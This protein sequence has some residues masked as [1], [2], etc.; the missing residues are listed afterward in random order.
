MERFSLWLNRNSMYVALLAALIATCGSLYFSEVR[1]YVPCVLCWYQRILM[2]PLTGVIAV[3]LLRRDRNLPYYVLP[4]S[5]YGVGMSGYHYLLEKTDLFAG[6]A[7]CAQGVSCTT[8]WINWFGFVTIPF[9]AFTAFLIIT[10]MSVI[11]LLNGEP[12]AEDEEGERLRTPWL[13][14]SGVVVAVLA[15]FAALFISGSASQ[16]AASAAPSP[17]AAM[18][19]TPGPQILIDGA[20]SDP[21][22]L[23]RGEQLYLQSCAACHGMD[24]LGVTNLGN[25]LRNS[26]FLANNSD[27]EVLAII[28]QG[29]ELNDPLNT[30]GLVMPP[31]GGRPDLSDADILAI[32][33]YMR[34]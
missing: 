14:V 23:A 18:A 2:Y 28:R 25:Q 20:V 32:I 27:D 16:A 21:A 5:L 4:L 8:Q 22:T 31:S 13:Q 34:Q 3:G 15:V 1:G 19:V 7:A 6:S 26:E 11:A 9:L 33:Q 30:T 10:L 12:A 17:F 24:G 29:R